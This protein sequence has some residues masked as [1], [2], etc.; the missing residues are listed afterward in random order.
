MYYKNIPPTLE[1]IPARYPKIRKL[2]CMK[3]F[4]CYMFVLI[5]F[6]EYPTKNFNMNFFN[7][8][9]LIE[10]T[11]HVLPIM[12]SY[13]VIATSLLMLQR[14]LSAIRFHSCSI[15]TPSKTQSSVSR[16]LQC[17]RYYGIAIGNKVSHGSHSQALRKLEFPCMSMAIITM[18]PVSLCRT[19]ATELGLRGFT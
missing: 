14:Y 16:P 1:L 2:L 8:T 4:M 13:L 9:Y 6:R 10:I 7:F 12:T 15:Q 17:Q 5:N 18:N 19:I 11:V 3:I